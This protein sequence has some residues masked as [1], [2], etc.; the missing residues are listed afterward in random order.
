[1]S[2]FGKPVWKVCVSLLVL[3]VL[4]HL[5]Q[6][7]AVDQAV[8]DRIIQAWND[9]RLRLPADYSYQLAITGGAIDQTG[10]QVIKAQWRNK[11][12][13]L[14]NNYALMIGE[15]ETFNQEK[16]YKTT[17]CY[18]FNPDY[19]AV[20]LPG[21]EQNTWYLKT[22]KIDT[23]EWTKSNRIDL[24]KSHIDRMVRDAIHQGNIFAFSRKIPLLDLL[25]LLRPHLMTVVE[26]DQQVRIEFTCPPKATPVEGLIG[27]TL[28]FD[29]S[30]DY[31]LISGS[32][33]FSQPEG[34]LVQEFLN[35]TVL[36]R[37][38]HILSRSEIKNYRDGILKGFGTWE[39]SPVA[40]RVA[41]QDFYISAFGL[42]E[43]VGVV[44]PRRTPVYVWLLV[45]AGVLLTLGIFFRWLARRLRR[46]ESEG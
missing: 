21:K 6:G 34:V 18:I 3:S 20:L 44:P 38:D 4:C 26:E 13:G 46:G 15:V 27:G 41:V 32:L 16:L 12:K 31:F 28:V 33:K 45:A 25:V 14:G 36:H 22:I 43:P 5:S 1:M 7:V 8:I 10:Q 29:A 2:M 35:Q 39:C 23:L 17:E 42:P 37:G 11:Y 40:E 19:T 24:D 9:K 30:K